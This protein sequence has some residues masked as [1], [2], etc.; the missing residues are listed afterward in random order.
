MAEHE[1]GYSNKPPHTPNRLWLNHVG[2]VL[3]GQYE[4][5]SVDTEYIRADLA[6]ENARKAGLW[7]ALEAVIGNTGEVSL[8][9]L[10]QAF[11]EAKGVDGG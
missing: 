3:I 5:G 1:K 10:A 4:P 2:M 11:I 6:A 7:D 9:A 8:T